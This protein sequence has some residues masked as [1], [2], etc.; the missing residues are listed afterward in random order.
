M[1]TARLGPT[2][3]A[4][5]LAAALAV[6]AAPSAHAQTGTAAAPD[7]HVERLEHNGIGYEVTYR[8]LVRTMEKT[9][10]AHP[11]ARS[12]LQRCRAVTEI[13]IDREVRLPDGSAALSHRLTDMQR[14]TAHH[15]GPCEQ[16]RHALAKARLRQADAIA[17]QVRAMAASDRPALLAQIDAARALAV[18]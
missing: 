6:A 4:A 7:S 5:S 8:P 12:T 1:N 10:G 9:I 13:A 18:N 17:A 3:L 16:N 11:G 2:S 14:I 15:I